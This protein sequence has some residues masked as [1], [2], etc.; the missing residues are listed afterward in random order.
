MKVLIIK[1]DKLIYEGYI[2]SIKLPGILGSFEVLKN[3]IN[4]LSILTKGI[5]KLYIEKTKLISTYNHKI[6]KN[7]TNK[8]ILNIHINI[9]KGFIH[10][11]KNIIDI[12]I[13]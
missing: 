6:F 10:I 2:K 13:F 4:F 12:L 5:I 11:N 1:Y 8:N 9:I 3:H 7:K